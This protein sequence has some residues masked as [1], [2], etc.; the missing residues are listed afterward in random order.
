MKGDIYF[1]TCMFPDSP[2][3]WD[4]LWRRAWSSVW[5]SPGSSSQHW[6]YPKRSKLRRTNQQIYDYILL[7]WRAQVEI[8]DHLYP[9]TMFAQIVFNVKTHN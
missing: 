7:V 5:V 1:K 3:V 9:D 4:M 2:T 6:L 8:I